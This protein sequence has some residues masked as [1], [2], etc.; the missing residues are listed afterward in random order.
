MVFKPRVDHAEDVSP[1]P[2]SLLSAGDD[3]KEWDL[4][5]CEAPWEAKSVLPLIE[6]DINKRSGHP[7]SRIKLTPQH[8]SVGIES[9][10]GLRQDARMPENELL[11]KIQ[12]KLS[13]ATLCS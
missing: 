8:N 3:D 9:I 10:L 4:V 1:V 11:A 7:V 5:L 13:D 6:R 12:S 2:M